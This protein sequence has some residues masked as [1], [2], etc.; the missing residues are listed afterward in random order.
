MQARANSLSTGSSSRRKLNGITQEQIEYY[1]EAY[2]LFDTDHSGFIDV[3]ELRAV[4]RHC[5]LDPTEEEV[6]TMIASVDV[7]NTGTIDFEEFLIMMEDFRGETRIHNT[8]EKLHEAFEAMDFDKNGF[9][10]A[11]DLINV[12]K[13]LGG[14]E[15]LREDEA[16]DMIR[17]ADLDGDGVI[18]FH[19]FCKLIQSFYN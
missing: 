1:R 19:D 18:N 2:S 12:V 8:P 11:A 4:M 13:G 17:D 6:H 14:G 10:T 15:S 9:I 7:D 16:L 5:G 3:T